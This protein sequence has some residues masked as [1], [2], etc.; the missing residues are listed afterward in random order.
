MLVNGIGFWYR[1]LRFPAFR[2]EAGIARQDC[3]PSTM[4]AYDTTFHL[5]IQGKKQIARGVLDASAALLL[6][7]RLTRDGKPL[8]AGEPLVLDVSE[9][10][11]RGSVAVSVLSLLGERGVEVRGLT[12]DALAQ[13]RQAGKA[14][15]TASAAG[16]KPEPGF[17]ESVGRRVAG[18]IAGIGETLGFLGRLCVLFV[19]TA[20]GRERPEGFWKVFAQA[21]AD[22]VPVTVLVGFLLGLILAFESSIPLQMFGAEVYVANLMGVA[23]F[24]ELAVLVAAIVMAGRTASA[25]SAEI[26]TMVVDEEVDALRAMGMDPVARLALPRVL[27]SGLALP[28]LS[29]FAG[30]SGLIGGCLVL[31]LYGY[32]LP[33]YVEHVLAFCKVK[34][35]LLSL[36]KA[37]VF[38]LL[39]GGIGCHR[40]LLTGGGADA[41]GR[42]TTAAV[43]SA[44]VVY[45]LADGLFAILSAALGL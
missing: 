10:H 33:I 38:G 27:A 35:V 30:L 41:V 40:G 23:I 3:L 5:E 9:A 39:I 21:G 11:V 2:M 44:I 25:F 24:R 6:W 13:V 12:G 42:A 8:S 32:S 28:L 4:A 22:A 26:G 20:A 18:G 16:H 7:S 43:V 29:V 17:F 45:A 15:N 31:M 37:A 1:L 14:A 19:R 34:D 36:F